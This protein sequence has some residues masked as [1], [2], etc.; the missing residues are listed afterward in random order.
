MNLPLKSACREL[1]TYPRHP[2]NDSDIT[3]R[4]GIKG[5]LVLCDTPVII[6]PAN[7]DFSTCSQDPDLLDMNADVA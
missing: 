5:N 3:I 4:T 7:I 2:L 1:C 6:S